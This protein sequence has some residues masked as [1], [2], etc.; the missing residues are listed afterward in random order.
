MIA[1]VYNAFFD[2]S[3]THDESEVIAVGGLI[4]TYEGW[5]RWEIEWDNFK[6]AEY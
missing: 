6:I 1:K 2:E 4:G 5:S 3:G